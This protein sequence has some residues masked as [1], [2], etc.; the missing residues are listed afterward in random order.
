MEDFYLQLKNHKNHDSEKVHVFKHLL[1]KLITKMKAA[2]PEFDA[3]FQEIYFGGSYFDGIAL[4]SSDFDLNIIFKSEN[5][6]IHIANVGQNNHLT[7]FGHLAV[8]PRGSLSAE[9]KLMMEHTEGGRLIISPNKVFSILQ[10]A[11][12]R[13]LLADMQCEMKFQGEI[14]KVMVSRGQLN[15]TYFDLVGWLVVFINWF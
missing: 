14:Y 10:T 4:S 9:E 15:D 1:E 3:L 8:I 6:N 13:A 7:N 2:S 5:F 11:V 12:D